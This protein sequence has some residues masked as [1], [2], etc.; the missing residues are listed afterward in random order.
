[1]IDI[2]KKIASGGF[3]EIAAM[4]SK[5]WS[6]RGIGRG[7]RRAKRVRNRSARRIAERIAFADQ[8]A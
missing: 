6:K 8:A 7:F 1:M 5:T 3:D 2:A 4:T